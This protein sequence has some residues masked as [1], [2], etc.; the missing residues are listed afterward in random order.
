LTKAEVCDIHIP[1]D[2]IH[3]NPVPAGLGEKKPRLF[4]N[5]ITYNRHASREG[6]ADFPDCPGG[7]P[8]KSLGS[9]K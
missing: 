5:V 2:G 4:D 8:L 6:R 7:N 1:N 3:S 9:E